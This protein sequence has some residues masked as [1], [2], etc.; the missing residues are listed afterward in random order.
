MSR[1]YVRIVVEDIFKLLNIVYPYS[2]YTCIKRIRYF[3][4]SLWIK[5]EFLS[6]QGSVHPGLILTGGKKIVIGKGSYVDKGGV[7]SVWNSNKEITPCLIIGDNC[8]IG[9]FNHISAYNHVEIGDGL[10]TGRWV[11]ITDN[12]H[13]DTKLEELGIPPHDRQ[14]YSKGPVYIGN[15]VWIGDKVTILAN[16]KIGDGVV[17]AANSVVTKDVP[18]F[19]VVAGI[20]AKIIKCYNANNI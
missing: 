11:T 1:R 14:L 18:A 16:V 9:E 12:G 17:I 7:L 19:S 4:Y 5:N 8:C 13:G 2:F 15:N 6:C 10:M 20:P 3:F